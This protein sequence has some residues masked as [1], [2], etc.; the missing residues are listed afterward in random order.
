MTAVAGYGLAKLY[1]VDAGWA[2]EDGAASA[3]PAAWS[4]C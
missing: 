1:L 4:R 2:V 3:W